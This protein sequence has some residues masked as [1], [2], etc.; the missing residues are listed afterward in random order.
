MEAK[1]QQ[2]TKVVSGKRLYN[3]STK[4][5]EIWRHAL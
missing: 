4:E 1:P 3:F 5:K 2:F